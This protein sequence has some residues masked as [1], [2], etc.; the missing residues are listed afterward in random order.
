VLLVI[1]ETIPE[2]GTAL[3]QE[4]LSELSNSIDKLR[5][6][7]Q[8]STLPEQVKRFI[9]EQLEIIRRA[10]HEE[11]THSRE[12]KRSKQRSGMQS[13]MQVSIPKLLPSTRRR[14]LWTT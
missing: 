14:R 7:I 5:D 4:E 13:F 11:T 2:D 9:F 3:T 8:D 6:E 12:L 10:I 1:G